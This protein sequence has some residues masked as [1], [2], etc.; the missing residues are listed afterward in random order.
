MNEA[1]AI[2][3]KLGIRLATIRVELGMSQE[4]MSDII[5]YKYY[6]KIEEGRANLTLETLVKL[7]N[8]FNCEIADFFCFEN[9]PKKSPKLKRSGNK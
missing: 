2:K 9:L 3:R 6:Q 8:K 7:K 5:D 4:D 1:K